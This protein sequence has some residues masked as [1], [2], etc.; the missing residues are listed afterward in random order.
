M[1]YLNRLKTD[2]LIAGERYRQL[3]AFRHV[4]RLLEVGG[5]VFFFEI[6]HRFSCRIGAMSGLLFYRDKSWDL[7][8][9]EKGERQKLRYSTL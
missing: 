7:E 3:L 9:G 4:T 1:V 2:F 5:G 6:I 8:V